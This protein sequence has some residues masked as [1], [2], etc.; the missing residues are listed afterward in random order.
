MRKI[1]RNS[2]PAQSVSF[3]LL[4]MGSARPKPQEANRLQKR[5]DE[6]KEQIAARG[7][8]T[9]GVCRY[10]S[11][12]RCHSSALAR[13]SGAAERRS[14]PC[15]AESR[16]G[17]C[18]ASPEASEQQRRHHA[19]RLDRQSAESAHRSRHGESHLAGALWH[20][21]SWIPP[22]TSAAMAPSRLIPNCSTGW[23]ANSFARAGR[24]SRCTDSLCFRPPIVSRRDMMTVAAAK[25]ADVRLLWRYPSRR[26]DGETI[27]DS[28]LAVSDRLQSH[29]GWTWL[30]SVRQARWTD[31]VSTRRVV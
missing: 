7:H 22:T 1:E 24:S 11:H 27:R 21:A 4:T 20:R 13:G 29:D 12:S 3:R 28:M 25:D 26:L 17:R 2:F 14:R 16:S 5:K 10:L 30:R 6:L 18:H 19:R 23:R 31:R 15:R 8:R 9:N